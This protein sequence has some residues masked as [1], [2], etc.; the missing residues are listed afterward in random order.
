MDIETAVVVIDGQQWEKDLPELGDLEVLVAPW[1]NPA[2]DRAMQKGVRALPAGLRADGN[3]EPAAYFRVVGTVMAKTI[4]FGWKNF[5]LAG[6]DKPFDPAYAQTLLTDP[7][8]K[9]FRD[10]VVA[11]AKRVQ[12]GVKAEQDQLLGNSTASSSGSGT[13][14]ATSNV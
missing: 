3:I 12:L 2:F 11:A 13:G 4:L 14:E 8:Y 7:K 9:P 5:K 1:E 6:E 10:G